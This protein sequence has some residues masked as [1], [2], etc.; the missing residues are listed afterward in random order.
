MCEVTKR[1][2]SDSAVKG[3]PADKG[4]RSSVLLGQSTGCEQNHLPH[5]QTFL[6]TT[7]NSV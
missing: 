5:Y 2:A 7:G 6:T 3:P 1:A 4:P